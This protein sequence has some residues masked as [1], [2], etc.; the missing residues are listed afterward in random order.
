ME[1]KPAEIPMKSN[2]KLRL[3]G[4]KEVNQKQY[5][6]FIGKLIYLSHTHSNIAFVVSIVSQFIHIHKETYLE[7]VYRILRYLKDN[8]YF[9]KK[10]ITK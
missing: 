2:I 9:L 10:D 7:I 5:Q 8:I 6:R 4:G 1:Y 3:E